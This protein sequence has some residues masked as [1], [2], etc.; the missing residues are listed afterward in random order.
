MVLYMLIIKYFGGGFGDIS[1]FTSTFKLLLIIGVTIFFYALF[2]VTFKNGF[3]PILDWNS[4]TIT[5]RIL[6]IS[7]LILAGIILGGSLYAYV[8]QKFVG[9][10]GINSYAYNRFVAGFSGGTFI[11][12]S[13]LFFT[14]SISVKINLENDNIEKSIEDKFVE[15][16]VIDSAACEPELANMES[17]VEGNYKL[18]GRIGS[19]DIKLNL[20]INNGTKELIGNYVYIRNGCTYGSELSLSGSYEYMN[21]N[22]KFTLT[23]ISPKGEISGTW[24]GIMEYNEDGSIMLKGTMVNS[25]NQVFNL[26]VLGTKE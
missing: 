8:V 7:Y 9:E 4:D 10:D 23:E 22:N 14:A 17:F 20:E 13:I 6:S 2:P 19:Y 18:S 12:F 5:G 25:R 11:A 15:E 1:Y 3:Y 24:N 16:V 26:E 21:G